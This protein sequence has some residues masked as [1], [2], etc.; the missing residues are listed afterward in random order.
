MQEAKR[1]IFRP[2]ALRRYVQSRTEPI[3]PH[4]VSPRMLLGLWIL[5]G[6]LVVS[7][8]LA[9]FAQVPVYASGSAVVVDGKG[10]TSA[11]GDA[12]LIVVF[13][14]PENLWRL[15]VGQPLLLPFDQGGKRIGRSIMAIEPEVHSPEMAQRRFALS[16]GAALAIRQPSAVAMTPLE[17][18]STGLPAAAYVGSVFRAEIEVGSRRLLSFLPLIG[19]FF[20]E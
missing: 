7:G 8:F 14:P 18:L 15:R 12:V 4:L 13:V 3:L 20:G 16:A 1:P 2:D 19:P 11:L 10:N 5:L 17:P 9:W 6:L